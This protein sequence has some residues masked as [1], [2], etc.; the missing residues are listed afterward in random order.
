LIAAS[1]TYGTFNGLDRTIVTSF[2]KYQGQGCCR[3]PSLSVKRQKVFGEEVNS[4]F[5]TYDDRPADIFRELVGCLST[6]QNDDGKSV[7]G[8][9]ESRNHD[10]PS[11]APNGWRLRRLADSAFQ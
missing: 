6:L 7:E 1:V 2:G 10:S 3:V 5:P 11:Y 9:G 8:I 4:L